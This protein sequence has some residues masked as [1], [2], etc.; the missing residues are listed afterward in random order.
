MA[1]GHVDRA[2]SLLAELAQ[3]PDGL[4][5]EH[6]RRD[7]LRLVR[8]GADAL[9]GAGGA[10]VVVEPGLVVPRTRPRGGGVTFRGELFSLL[11]CQCIS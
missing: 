4:H 3:A 9:E 6:V 1:A 7:P 11:A 8:G 10:A 2:A 5:V